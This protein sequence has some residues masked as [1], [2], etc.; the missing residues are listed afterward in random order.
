[1]RTDVSRTSAVLDPRV[2]HDLGRELGD[3]RAATRI[4]ARFLSLLPSR[5]QR[6]GRS[7]RAR[8]PVAA[9]D[10]VLSLKVSAAMVGGRSLEEQARRLEWLVR[11]GRWT[12]AGPALTAVQDEVGPLTAQLHALVD[13]RTATDGVRPAQSR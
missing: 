1:M 11:A 2:V 12:D 9:L 4:V 13:R 7:V 8:D 3:E 10:A 5:A 6:L